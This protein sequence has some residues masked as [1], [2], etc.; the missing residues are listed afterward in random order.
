M[1][2]KRRIL[3][4]G[5]AYRADAITWMDGLKQFGDF[6]IVTWEL[7]HPGHNLQSRFKRFVEYLTALRTIRRV[8]REHQPD[9]VIAE[10]TTSYGFLAASCG[11]HPVAI[12]QQGR[13]DLWPER[14][15][16]MPLKRMLQHRA[17]KYADLIHAWGPVMTV[18]MREAGVD[19][20]K[21]MVLP[22][23][24]DLARFRYEED[25]NRAPAAIVTRSL[26]PE[27]R[28][29]VILR[30][31]SLLASRGIQL[32]L[33]IVG[34]GSRKQYLQQL[35]QELDIADQVKFT[36][37]IPNTQLPKLLGESSIYL[38][39]PITEGVS[40]SLFEAM[41]CGSYPIV[42]DLPGNRS[43]ISHRDNGQLVPVD[44]A[45]ALANEIEWALANPEL[46][47]KASEHNRQFVETY[48]DFHTNMKKIADRYHEM[49]NE[50]EAH[51]RN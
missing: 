3:F 10:R 34:D 2:K 11:L 38:S 50:K 27:Y 31:F 22:K 43:W 40:A 41:A 17:F 51:V 46:R 6:E 21:V 7:N 36:G 9:M 19:M 1:Q 4:L 30:A 32:P 20:S 18:S 5:E 47:R 26:Q 28:H 42:T 14:S 48:A 23:G 25:T 37:R 12:A 8:I 13:T 45:T 39:M 24:I 35:A 33:I 49:I 44:D 29:D 15:L 16:T